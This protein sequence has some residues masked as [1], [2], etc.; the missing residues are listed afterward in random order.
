MKPMASISLSAGSLALFINRRTALRALARLGA[1]SALLIAAAIGSGCVASASREDNTGG[2][3]IEAEPVSGVEQLQSDPICLS[4]VPG[5]YCGDDMISGG[6]A[7]TLYLCSG[8]VN[9]HAQVISICPDGCHVSRPGVHDYCEASSNSCETPGNCNNCVLFAR[10]RRPDLPHG[11]NSYSDKL[12]IINTHT[13]Q[14]GAIAVVNTGDAIGHMA[15]V[16]SVNGESITISEGNW[17]RGSC[18]A[19]TGTAG[20]LNIVGFFM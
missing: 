8:G 15:Y 7:E 1:P 9:A 14:P 10:C 20:S 3:S 5:R 6:S 17:P 19:R 12:A 2:T 16:E 13:P 18:G 4:S 11:L